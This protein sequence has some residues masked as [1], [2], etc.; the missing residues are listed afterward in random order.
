MNERRIA[1]M[2]IIDSRR[3]FT[4]RE[5]AERFG[6]SVR[7]IQRDLDYLQQ[8][9]FPLYTEQGPHGGYRALPNRILP[10]LRLNQT[11]ALG[12]FLSLQVLEKI[13]DFPFSAVR[14]HLSAHYY[15]SLPQDIQD[16]IDR[17]RHYIVFY[18]QPAAK[19]APYTTEILQ[20]AVE[21]RALAFQYQSKSG[22]RWVHAFP[23]GLYFDNGF[24]YMPALYKERILLY[25]ADRI[26]SASIMEETM[27]ELPTL[28]EWLAAEEQREGEEVQLQF[29]EQGSRIAQDDRLFQSV[30]N[31]IWQSRV[32]YEEMAYL[33]RKLVSYGPE[34][35]VISP[36]RL[37]EQV[38]GLLRQSLEQYML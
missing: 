14:S 30:A 32:P 20:A 25:R 36:P 28:K 16:T 2:Q 26:Q 19:H 3:K 23:V 21:Q 8:I 29:T 22:T 11:E 31:Q 12:L 15:G 38:M 35:K 34:V 24:W 7:T 10:P 6:V 9:G 37:R 5:L 13:S 27:P 33:A 18:L 4:A 17:M 1:M